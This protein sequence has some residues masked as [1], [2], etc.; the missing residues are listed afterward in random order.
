MT[1]II[2]CSFSSGLD[3]MKRKDQKDVVKVLRMLDQCKRYSVF[4]TTA[5]MDIA[6]MI[7][8]LHHKGCTRVQPDGSRKEYGLLL[9]T[10][11]G[12]FPWTEIELTDGGK[13]LLEDNP[14]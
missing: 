7:T 9:K 4:E 13:R 10:I 8:R 11:G 1:S 3:D 2:V 12:A 5:N 14:A 6:R